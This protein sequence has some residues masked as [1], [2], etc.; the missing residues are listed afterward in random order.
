VEDTATALLGPLLP[1]FEVV[2]VVLLIA[3]AAAL[4]IIGREDGR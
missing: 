3:L 4:A 2:G 1:Y